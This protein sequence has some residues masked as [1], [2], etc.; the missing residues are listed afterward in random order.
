MLYRNRNVFSKIESSY[1]TDP[2]PTGTDAVLTSGLTFTPYSGPTVSRN[3]DRSTLGGQSVVNTNP[4]VPINFD[5]EIAGSGTPATVPA[6]SEVLRACGFSV[7]AASP[8]SGGQIYSPLSSSFPSITHWVWVDGQKQIINGARGNMSLS[9]TAGQIPHFS[10]AFIGKYEQPTYTGVLSANVS[11][12]STPLAVTNTNTPTFTLGG[13][14][15]TNLRVESFTLD[16]QNQIVARNIIGANEIMITDRNP[17]GT[18]K[19]E[20][21]TAKN[22]FAGGVESHSGITTLAMNLVHGTSSG[23]KVKI[24]APALQITNITEENSDGIF[25]YTMSVA[26]TP[27]SGNDEFTITTL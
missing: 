5:V 13:S 9:L 4:Q 14:P 2:T 16:M 24:A 10:F 15:L 18:I 17:V 19:F 23:N 27:V 11:D 20:A 8:T 21:T 22:W 7:A 25:V 3:L 12:Y 1:A 26:F 6:Y